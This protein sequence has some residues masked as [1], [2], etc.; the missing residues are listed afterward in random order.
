MKMLALL[1]GMMVA[2]IASGMA[3]GAATMKEYRW[4]NRVLVLFAGA[5]EPRLEEQRTILMPYQDGLAD[6]DMVI[7]AVVDD[8]IEPIFGEA[9]AGENAADLRAT[10]GVPED[11][12]FTALLVGKDGGVKWRENRPAQQHELFGLID[13]MPM[14][15]NEL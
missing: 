2:M 5:G 1:M 7:F 14:R 9:P 15:R 13:S 4:K 12:P 6:R 10:F 3:Q 8:R 11:A